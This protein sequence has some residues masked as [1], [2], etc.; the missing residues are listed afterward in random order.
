MSVFR[1]VEGKSIFEYISDLRMQHAVHLLQ[2]EDVKVL[3]VARTLGYK[4]PNHFST[5]FKRIYGVVPTEF[6][7]KPTY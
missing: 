2:D 4:N 3:Q 5:A 7:Y 1:A 6:R